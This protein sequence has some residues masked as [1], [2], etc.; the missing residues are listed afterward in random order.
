MNQAVELPVTTGRGLASGARTF[1]PEEILDT[2]AEAGDMPRHAVPFER[3]CASR[4]KAPAQFD[5][6]LEGR[7]GQHLTERRAHRCERQDVGSYGP[8]DAADVGTF[9]PRPHWLEGLGD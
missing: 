5:H 1:G 2:A 3:V 6:V 4:F 8:A 9:V 7:V